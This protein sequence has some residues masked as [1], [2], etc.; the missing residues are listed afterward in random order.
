MILTVFCLKE[1]DNIRRTTKNRFWI[2]LSSARCQKNPLIID[3]LDDKPLTKKLF[4]R[5]LHLFGSCVQYFGHLFNMD[6]LKNIGFEIKTGL[7]NFIGWI[8]NNSH[9]MVIQINESGN[10]LQS[11]HSPNGSITLLSEVNVIEEE[12]RT[13]LYLG[14]FFNNYVGK[15]ILPSNHP[16]I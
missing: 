6:F 11:L 13:I 10:I 8:L 16:L 14:S 15:L 7:N 9:G 1:P 12:N 2:A 4:F 3:W 5:S